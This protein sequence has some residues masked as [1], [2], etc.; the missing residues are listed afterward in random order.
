MQ[1][2]LKALWWKI[3]GRKSMK[4]KEKWEEID[5]NEGEKGGNA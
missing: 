3:N 5:E 1:F 4:M 2:V